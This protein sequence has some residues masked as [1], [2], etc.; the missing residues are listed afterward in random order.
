LTATPATLF[1]DAFEFRRVPDPE[2]T[3]ALP[4]GLAA[5]DEQRDECLSE[6]RIQRHRTALSRPSLSK[7]VRCALDD[8]VIHPTVTV[9]DYGCGRGSDV[10]RLTELGI[11]CIGWDPEHAPKVSMGPA[12]VV[13]IGY[14]VN[15][16]ESQRER[17]DALIRAWSFTRQVLVVS[18]RLTFDAL[19]QS[20][21]P[22]EDGFLT[23][24]GTFQKFYGHSELR[25]WIALSLDI[26]P[27]AAA[28]GVFYVFRDPSARESFIAG[29][30]RRVGTS[31][32][33]SRSQQILGE[34]RE[35][36]DLLIPFFAER[37]RLPSVRECPGAALLYRSISSISTILSTI[38]QSVGGDVFDTVVSRRREDLL[39]YLALAKFGKRVQLRRLPED[40]QLDILSFFSTYTAACRASDGL[41][42]K[43]GNDNHLNTALESASIG[44]LTG[45]AL[46]VHVT[47][48][49][50]LPL[51]ARLFEGCARIYAGTVEGA[52]LVKLHR[53]KPLVS[54]LSYPTFDEDAHPALHASVVV[55]LG[56]LS[57]RLLGYSNSEDPPV[58]HRKEL[59]VAPD[60]QGRQA[61]ANL[62]HNEE[63]AGL[64]SGGDRIGTRVGWLRALRARGLAVRGHQLVRIPPST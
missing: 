22:F 47:A 21:T 6:R 57:V 46:Y 54:Y 33:V 34:H 39:V 17:R 50:E 51:L 10:A 37:G 41:L 24:V 28:P 58:L 14:V 32:R 61:F 5:H 23:S 60:Y 62:T 43:L 3:T 15:V 56:R 9:L 35:T 4:A 29:R 19:G 42:F 40:L 64:L 1:H 2:R 59:F 27:V 26:S 7:P 45:S 53:H 8:G 36:F 52:T 44:K 63:T 25:D 31:V 12:D 30:L 20:L 13:N 38:R 11:A 48:I 18:A 49:S 16:I 55:D